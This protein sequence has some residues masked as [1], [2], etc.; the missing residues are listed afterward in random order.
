MTVTIIAAVI[1]GV[2]KSQTKLKFLKEQVFRSNRV[3][4]R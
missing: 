3:N 1:L 4:K 2:F